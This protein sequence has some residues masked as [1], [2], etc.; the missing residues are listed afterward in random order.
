MFET[1]V[2]VIFCQEN[3]VVYVIE[4]LLFLNVLQESHCFFKTYVLVIFSFCY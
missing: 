4:C 3:F 2:C 1:N